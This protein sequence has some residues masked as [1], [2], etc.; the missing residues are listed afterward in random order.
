MKT[1][2]QRKLIKNFENIVFFAFKKRNWVYLAN[3]F[4]AK[5]ILEKR[6]NETNEPII[7]K[8]TINF[9]STLFQRPQHLALELSKLDNLVLYTEEK[10]LNPNTKINDNLIVTNFSLSINECRSV[11]KR[12]FLIVTSASRISYNQLKHVKNL[13][14][15]IIYEYIDEISEEIHDTKEA[16]KIYNDL[17]SFNPLLVLTT[18]Q[19]LYDE[20]ILRFPKER[21]L[22]NKNGVNIDDFCKD[23]LVTPEDMK[24]ILEQNKPIIGYYGA[25]A[26][27]LD[28]NIL[29]KLSEQR[30]D[31]NFVYIGCDYNEGLACLEKRDNVFYLGPKDYKELSNYSRN[32]D[33]AMIPFKEGEIAKS[34]SPLKLFEYMAAK[35][36]V[37]C[38]KDLLEC[39]G[40]EGVL[41]SQNAD[42]FLENIDKAIELSKDVNIQNQLF[43]YAKQNTWEQRAKSI[44]EKIKELSQYEQNQ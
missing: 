11:C 16:R 22:L 29:N 6:I 35:K 28:Y 17:E 18:A 25:I 14:V 10:N 33:V 30:P 32:F 43:E 1:Q 37:V 44:V 23:K 12:C 34:T 24:P 4:K 41:I 19:K 8:Y 40:Y 39:Y 7:I 9:Y 31:Y 3:Y 42:E 2:H 13:G 5:K 38:T 36:P 15:N 26:S 21:V 27:W 20:M